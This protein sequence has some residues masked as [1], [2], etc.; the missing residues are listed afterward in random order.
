[1]KSSRALGSG[2]AA[3]IL[4]IS[5]SAP[6]V[7]MAPLAAQQ[8]GSA[9]NRSV[10]VIMK[11]HHLTGAEAESD[12]APVLNALAQ[13]APRRVKRF[14]AVNSFATTVSADELEHL[15]ADPNVAMVVP[16]LIIRR[17]NVHA[18]P[19]AS[20]PRTTLTPNVIPGACG[21]NGKVLLDPEALQTTNTSSDDP[22]AKTARSLGF[23]GKGVKVAWIADGIDTQNVN[24]IR[25]STG[26][27]VFVDYQVFAAEGAGQPTTGGEAFLDANSIAG[28]GVHVYN[29]QDFSAQPTPSTC[30]V[31]IEGMAPGA[32]LVG[33][34]VFSSFDVTTESNF[35]QAIDYA[36]FTAHVDVLNESFG[37]NPFPDSSALNAT[38]VFND[39]AIRAGITVTVSSGDAGSTNTIGSPATDPLSIAVGGSTAFRFY[40]QTNYA[41]ARYF[42]TT[43][44]LNDNISS[45]SSGGYTQAGR[46]LDLVAPGDL[47]FASCDASPNFVD[48]TNFKGVS[49]DVEESG[50]TSQSAPLTAGAAALV[51]EAYRNSHHGESPTPALVKQI[52]TSTAT[53]LGVPAT[54]QGAGLLNSYKAVLLAQSIKTGQTPIGQSLLLSQ[55]QLNAA[56]NPGTVQRWPVTVTNTGAQAQI[57]HLAGKTFGAHENVQSGSIT[58]K[59]GT[60]PE[61]ANYQG[62]QNNYGVFHFRVPSGADRLDAAIAYPAPVGSNNNARVRLILVDPLGR[63]AAHSLPQGVGNFGNVDVRQPVAGTWTGVIFGD[64]QSIGGTNGKVPWQVYTQRFT[65]FGSVSPATLSLKS[66]QSA[67]FEVTA[68]TPRT[69][70]DSSGSIVLTST[71]GGTDPF[72]GMESNSIPVTLRSLVNLSN[73]GHF[74]GVLTGGNGRPPGE[75][76]VNYYEFNV[77][78]GHSSITADVTLQ[79]DIGDMVGTYLIAPDGT[80]LG[81]GQNSVNGVNTPSITAYTH[82]PAPGRWT[83]IVQFAEPVVGDEVS[84]T[85]TGDIKLDDVSVSAPSLPNSQHTMLT[86]GVPVVVPVRI[87]NK[88]AAAEAFFIDARLNT[89]THIALGNLSPPPSSAG[90]PLPLAGA[91]PLWLMPTQTASMQVV[92]NATV[93]IEFDYGPNQGDP[94]LVAGPISGTQAAGQYAPG[95]GVVQQGVWFATPDEFGPF[96]GPAP[97]GVANFTMTAKTKAFDPAVTSAPGDLWLAAVDPAALASFAPVVIEPG[98]TVIVNVT[99]TPSGSPGTVVSGNLYVDDVESAVPPY[100]QLT[101]DELAAIPYTYTIK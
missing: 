24:F 51:I 62:L 19:A 46:T 52:L 86:A 16:D 11:N 21:A 34:D 101:G 5:G 22:H 58:L 93:P 33:L 27:S 60:S 6:A 47:G 87:T 40:A 98:Q 78:P 31:R 20:S 41:S 18:V 100:A 76:Q 69:P 12:R 38:K 81:F 66:G 97:A 89:V 85:F 70:G 15:K 23:T 28:Q 84:Q 29:V 55:N 17:P 10:I 71:G 75:G 96:S 74:Q 9:V 35:L 39:A 73:G 94:D 36:I 53:D 59:D 50:G 90:Y 57:V 82:N 3:A 56:A 4:F 37:S 44:W 45:L 48:C 80:A 54:E 25:P 99:I 1:M 72:V 61:F 14:Q 7:D 67:T 63:F 95:A 8:A 43:G 13:T 49:S 77:G 2:V 32:D 42:A 64:V 91:G 68:T 65:P 83:L 79:N 30:N 88:G 26:K 92:G